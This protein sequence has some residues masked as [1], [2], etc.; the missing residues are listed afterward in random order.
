MKP[1]HSPAL[2]SLAARTGRSPLDV[3]EYFNERSAIR[4]YDGSMPRGAAEEWAL[5]DCRAHFALEAS[6]LPQERAARPAD[7]TG[8]H[9]Q[10]F[11]NRDSVASGEVP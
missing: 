1:D 7:A 4:E 5:E 2:E 6:G 11:V 3:L 9:P 8:Q 10:T